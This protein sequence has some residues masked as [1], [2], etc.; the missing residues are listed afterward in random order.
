MLCDKYGL[1]KEESSDCEVILHLYKKLGFSAMVK[2]LE[3]EF[4][5]ILHDRNQ[6]RIYACR[7]ICGI[8]PLYFSYYNG[9]LY[10]A[11]ELKAIPRVNAQH[12]RPRNI[13]IFSDEKYEIQPYWIFP[14]G[15]TNTP[16]IT[17]GKYITTSLI[18][19]YDEIAD[20]IYKILYDSVAMRLESDREKGFF[21]SGGIDSSIICALAYR[22][23][24]TVNLS[25]SGSNKSEPIRCFT[26]GMSD[27]PDVAAAKEV[28]DFLNVDLTVIPF[29]IQQAIDD[30]P[31]L[32]W[33][34]ETYDTTTIRASAA[35]FA[36]CKWIAN[37]TD[38]K[39]VYSGEVADELCSSYLYSK[40][41]PSLEAL[42]EDAVRLLS[43]IHYFDALR[44]DRTCA[45]QGLECR[46]PYMNRAY[47]E[48]IL[49]LHPEFRRPDTQ[50][51]K[52]IIRHMAKKYNLLPNNVIWRQKDAFSDG[53]SGKD[54]WIGALK[55]YALETFVDIDFLNE[56]QQ[57]SHL[58][59][60]TLEQLLYRK[61]F[62]S[63]YPNREH[64]LPH[65]WM[66]K[67]CD[68]KDPSATYLDVYKP[69]VKK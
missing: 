63:M 28:A 14:S 65:F 34:L 46:V 35:Q 13:Y 39:V 5:I 11:S 37:N 54:N 51:E 42:H 60:E 6:N 30:L 40:Y 64:I 52:Y 32:I 61:L 47:I 16:T 20:N 12:I 3:G 27:S 45:S 9:E 18:A 68:A 23:N 21:L 41:A 19:Q 62:D 7:D 56:M 31:E 17:G 4:A 48:Y 49:Q 50:P 55:K 24:S 59:P 36:A 43:E 33:H 58:Q 26:I 29:S 2:E 66:P 38:I 69:T 53:I 1:P 44:L 57:Y 22:I 8:R 15:F 25:H 67:W 10:L